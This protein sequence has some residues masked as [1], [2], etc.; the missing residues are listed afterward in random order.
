MSPLRLGI[1]VFMSLAL[2][3]SWCSAADAAP[4]ASDA[5]LISEEDKWV[6]TPPV[7]RP[8]IF[9][10][11]QQ[12]LVLEK[13]NIPT[14]TG[15]TRPDQSTENDDI[16]EVTRAQVQRIEG[17]MSQRKWDEAIKVCDQAIKKLTGYPNNAEAVKYLQVIKGYQ[18][19]AQDALLR[20]EAQ[21][22]FDALNLKVEGIL[23]SENGP[24]L[25][26]ISGEA[27]ALGIND[28]VKDCVIINIDTDRVD[29]RYH[30]KRKRFEFPRYVG[31]D[32]KK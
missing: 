7:G 26:I 30:Y 8:D 22:A 1:Q 23:W 25:A 17:F 29:F 13:G 5:S 9:Y 21:A 19:Q 24:R 32:L 31:E 20:D 16:L 3:S 12:I 15:T 6:F 18:V 11:Y 27:R 4:A 28:R 10:D 14:D 2:A